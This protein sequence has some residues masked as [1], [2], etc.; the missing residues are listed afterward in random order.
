MFTSDL[1]YIFQWWIILFSL[2]LIFFPLTSLLF[3][4]FF[5]KGYIFS[6]IL[7][8]LLLSYSIWLLGSLKILNFSV[9]SLLIVLALFLV[10]NTYLAYQRKT[11]EAVLPN[12]KLF[13]FEEV[14]FTF[15]LI[16]WAW[17]RGHEPSIHGLEKFMDFGFINSILRADYFPPKDLW[18]TPDSIN[19][20]Y[21]GHLVTAVLT[22]LSGIDSIITYNLMLAT[23]FG[24][25]LAAS[26]SLGANLYHKFTVHSSRFT[27]LAG[28]LSS[29][30]V[31]LGGNLHTI[32]AFFQTY[33]PADQAVPFWTLPLKWNFSGYWYPNATRFIPFTIH[34]FPL[35]SFVVAD[36]H[37]HVLGIPFILL[38]LA[39]LLVIFFSSKLHI[40][41]YL[42]LS[43]LIAT[44]LMTNVLD[45]PIYLLVIF[46]VLLMKE[47]Q[48]LKWGKAFS[49]SIQSMVIIVLLTAVFS[50]PFWLAFKPFASGV[51]VLCAPQFL[52]NRGHLG[53]FLFEANHCA[54]SPLWMLAILWGF[55]YFV[56]FGFLTFVLPTKKFLHSIFR[57]L[58]STIYHLPSTD[59]LVL[60][61]ILSAT[62]LIFIPEF[63]YAKDIYPAHYRANTVF[64][65][66][67]QAFII[68]GLIS[69]YMITRILT[70]PNKTLRFTLYA[71]PLFL[72]F[73]LVAIYPNFAVNSFYGE[74]K[75]YQGLD[76][77]SY[78][79]ELYPADYQ[80]ILWLS[81]NVP[82]QPVI[83]EAQGDSYTDYARISSNTGLPTIIGWPVHEWLWRGSYDEAGKRSTEV[84][85]L[86]ES[87]DSEATKN[88]LK[89]YNVSYVYIGDLERQKYPN[90]NETKFQ[91][92]GKV[93][94]QSGNTRIYQINP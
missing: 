83:L 93:I 67:Y 42:L 43:L 7:G 34:E 73:S 40:T 70:L 58:P 87:Q 8:V 61:L 91:T 45:G 11:S 30:L 62:I 2:G 25:T 13:I 15:G 44:F 90:L 3:K 9:I 64:K 6:K 22:K 89:K 33:T 18:L 41:H 19:Y 50:L 74:L 75:T 20:Y 63:F 38:A 65:F 27:V 16:F 77:L 88:L 55:P 10:V 36:L 81:Q 79:S 17:V 39:L 12:L 29:F 82:G 32:Y 23:L 31:T 60:T 59:L 49:E 24:L 53:P 46:L 1:L 26:F 4:S 71:T 54:R 84:T 5:D 47:K 94:F 51:G 14:L 37:G 35:Y 28:L 78:L 69:G 86:Y 56:L 57:K 21:F 92:L 76:G 85:I 68:L 72:L 66:G 48:T 80:A 52:V